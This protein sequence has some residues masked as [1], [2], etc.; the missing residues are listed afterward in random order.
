MAGVTITPRTP[1]RLVLQVSTMIETKQY[2][3]GN[4]GLRALQ[5]FKEKDEEHLTVNCTLYNVVRSPE[6][7]DQWVMVYSH[8]DEYPRWMTMASDEALRAAGRVSR[9]EGLLERA[10]ETA[11][12]EGTPPIVLPGNETSN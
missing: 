2:N 1:L 5:K 12:R 7:R 3:L 10:M 4:D 6:G 9:A 8:V 11:E